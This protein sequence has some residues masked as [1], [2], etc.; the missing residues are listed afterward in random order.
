[1]SIKFQNFLDEDAIE[2]WDNLVTADESSTSA[3]RRKDLKVQLEN[4]RCHVELPKTARVFT[5][6]FCILHFKCHTNLIFFVFLQVFQITKKTF[7][8]K[9]GGK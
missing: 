4:Y 8:G 5:F 2:F 3:E 9:H 1:M 6:T 7:S